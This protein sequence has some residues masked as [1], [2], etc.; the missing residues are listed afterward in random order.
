VILP[1]HHDIPVD[2][3][4][5][6]RGQFTYRRDDEYV[7]RCKIC[8]SEVEVVG[9]KFGGMVVCSETGTMLWDF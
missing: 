6:D 1:D 9:D 7:D 3:Y 2:L 4:D 5:G 8:G